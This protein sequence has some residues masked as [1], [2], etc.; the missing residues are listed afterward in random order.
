MHG[1]EHLQNKAGL[2]LNWTTTFYSYADKPTCPHCGHSKYLYCDRDL[3]PSYPSGVCVSKTKEYCPKRVKRQSSGTTSLLTRQMTHCHTVHRHKGLPGDGRSRDT[4]LMRCQ[5]ILK[6]ELAKRYSNTKQVTSS[7][8]IHVFSSRF[9][10]ILLVN[11]YHLYNYLNTVKHQTKVKTHVQCCFFS[12]PKPPACSRKNL[13]RYVFN[14][15]SRAKISI[16]A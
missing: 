5:E 12:R 13:K 9:Y 10:W 15:I 2:W 3:D 8:L 11:R 14:V 1:F 6:E 4:D 7:K 16:K